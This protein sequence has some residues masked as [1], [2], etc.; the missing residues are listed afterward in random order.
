MGRLGLEH[1][2]NDYL[3]DSWA[4]EVV[5]LQ[6][7]VVLFAIGRRRGPRGFASIS[8]NSNVYR[9]ERTGAQNPGLRLSLLL[10]V[11]FALLTA[12]FCE[13]FCIRL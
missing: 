6:S 11:S 10:A 4:D 1:Y 12:P 8:K 9:E 3:K 2:A 5:K 7:A 13:Q